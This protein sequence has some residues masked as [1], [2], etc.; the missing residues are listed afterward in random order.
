[1]TSHFSAE[2]GDAL[3]MLAEFGAPVSFAFAPS[4]EGT[5]LAD[6]DLE[7]YVKPVPVTGQAVR[8]KGNPRVYAALSLVETD[9]PTL[10]FAAD[11]IG[12]EPAL[13]MFVTWG[14]HTYVAKSIEAIA[15]DGVTILARVVVTR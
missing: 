7:T 12:T 14:A 15:P 5:Y 1:M 8:V 6:I 4:D 13:G 2:H 3:T 11:T 9:S 10:L